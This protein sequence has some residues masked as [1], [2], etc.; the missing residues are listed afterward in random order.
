MANT[1]TPLEADKMFHIYNHAVGKENFFNS[2]D[3]YN[4]FLLKFK[5][6]L[7]N[8]IDIYAYCLMP[9]HFH[10]V[11]KVKSKEYI[12]NELNRLNR[13]TRFLKPRRSYNSETENF[14]PKIIS[15]QFS[16]FF[17]SYA[18]AYNKKNN[19]MGSLFK[20]RFNREPIEDENYLKKV[21]IYIH[22]NPVEAG[23]V[24]KQSEWKY[25]SY[26]SIISNKTTLLKRREVIEL[27]EDLENFIFCHY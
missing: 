14:I 15:R 20:N 12:I 11:I 1:K 25:S 10:F 26:N 8:Y 18:K 4:F 27:F 16:H 19:R 24:K 22:N 9:N 7:Q 5:K 13:P 3:N 17:N 21:I 23:F 2:T 6:Y